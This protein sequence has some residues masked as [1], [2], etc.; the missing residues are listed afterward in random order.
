M[1]ELTTEKETEAQKGEANCPKP[2]RIS[3]GVRILTPSHDDDGDDDDG[4]DDKDDYEEAVEGDLEEG[5]EEGE[6][7]EQGHQS[8]L[9]TY[10]M[11]DL[12]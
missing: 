3:A 5:E 10:Y 7:E 12:I 9:N 2:H 6:E 4:D 1:A 8:L 11:P